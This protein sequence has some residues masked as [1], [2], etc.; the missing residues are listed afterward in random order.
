M[1]W[2]IENGIYYRLPNLFF[3]RFQK[4]YQDWLKWYPNKKVKYLNKQRIAI[5]YGRG[6]K[7]KL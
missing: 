4:V 5:I 3:K 7:I 2:I 6:L 1:Q